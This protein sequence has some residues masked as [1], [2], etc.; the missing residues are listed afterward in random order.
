MFLPPNMRN[1]AEDIEESISHIEPLGMFDDIHD[2]LC[3]I[4]Q[5]QEDMQKSEEQAHKDR[6]WMIVSTIS[7]VIAAIAGIIAL[8]MPFLFS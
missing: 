3:K 8:V 2:V 5:V 1:I 4:E 7:S 6:K